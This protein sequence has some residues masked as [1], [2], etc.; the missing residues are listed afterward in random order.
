M[1][2]YRVKSI[3]LHYLNNEFDTCNKH[4]MYCDSCLK[5]PYLITNDTSCCS[6]YL[7]HVERKWQGRHCDLKAEESPALFPIVYFCINTAQ[8]V[9]THPPVWEAHSKWR[10]S[11]SSADTR[12]QRASWWL[13]SPFSFSP[14]SFIVNSVGEKTNSHA[15]KVRHI[16]HEGSSRKNVKVE[17]EKRLATNVP[18]PKMDH[19]CTYTYHTHTSK[20]E[21]NQYHTMCSQGLK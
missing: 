9:M 18:F 4:V 19:W 17:Q 13:I 7:A 6:K 8:S 12:S 11:S 20:P 10:S 15:R 5:A 2:F 14:F 3:P 21:T 1:Q 16:S